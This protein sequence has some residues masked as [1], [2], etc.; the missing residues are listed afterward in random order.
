MKAA[1]ANESRKNRGPRTHSQSHTPFDHRDRF[2]HHSRVSADGGKGEGG[3]V[4]GTAQPAFE[5][6]GL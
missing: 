3:S 5:A 1:V 6:K 2:V 4:G